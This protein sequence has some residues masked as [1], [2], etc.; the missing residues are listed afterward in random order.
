MNGTIEI[1]IDKKLQEIKGR[2]DEIVSRAF[3]IF[4]NGDGAL[5]VEVDRCDGAGILAADMLVHI[6][7]LKKFAGANTSYVFNEIMVRDIGEQAPVG[8]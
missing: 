4:K 5:C 2:C 3:D 1:K 8:P 7:I 6:G